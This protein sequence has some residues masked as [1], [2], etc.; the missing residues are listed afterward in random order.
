MRTRASFGAGVSDMWERTPVPAQCP[1][2]RSALE[3]EGGQRQASRMP[4]LEPTHRPL[5]VR[6]RRPVVT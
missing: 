6:L 4:A 1:F 5:A 3:P 2:L